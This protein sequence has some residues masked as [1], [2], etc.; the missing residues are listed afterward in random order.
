MK[1]NIKAKIIVLSSEKGGVGKST[2]SYNLATNLIYKRKS[3]L[4]IDLDIQRSCHKTFEMRN[5]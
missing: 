4:L 3:V 2:T 5:R 1:K